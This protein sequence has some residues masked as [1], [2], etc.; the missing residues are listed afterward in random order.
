MAEQEVRR[1]RAGLAA[2]EPAPAETAGRRARNRR[3]RAMDC[4]LGRVDADPGARVLSRVRRRDLDRAAGPEADPDEGEVEPAAAGADRAPELRADLRL[5]HAEGDPGHSLLGADDRARGSGRDQR[6]QDECDG[7]TTHV[8]F[9]GARDVGH[10]P[11]SGLDQMRFDVRVARLPRLQVQ[12]DLEP[13]LLV[14][15]RVRDLDDDGPVAICVGLAFDSPQEL[16]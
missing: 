1:A 4:G 11:R 6:E 2:S 5:G 3:E 14:A 10:D 8:S 16:E 7:E 15:E 9:I 12:I 13:R